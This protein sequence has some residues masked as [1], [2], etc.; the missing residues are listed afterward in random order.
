MS[1][2]GLKSQ[3]KLKVDIEPYGWELVGE[4]KGS[5]EPATFK[6]LKCGKLTT[7]SAA[8]SIR[9]TTCKNCIQHICLNCGKEFDISEGKGKK[10]TRRFCFECL[11]Q[12]TTKG[13]GR[14]EYHILWKKYVITKIKERY[15][16]S[17]CI[18]GYNKCF[19]ALD[20]HHLD[21]AMKEVNPSKI[22]H[23]SYK[24]DDI[25]RELDKCILVC[26]NCHR[27]IHSKEKI[28]ET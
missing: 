21:S 28:N 11:P 10:S 22:I 17:C 15:G 7:V 13:S 9:R 16:S 3:S 12:S 5:N 1:H 6:C 18:C 25:F 4:Y 23:S 24:L 8:K 27:E 26:A 2:R 19:D 20:F 14:N